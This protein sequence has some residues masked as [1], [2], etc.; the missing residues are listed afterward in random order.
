MLTILPTIIAILLIVVIGHVIKRLGLLAD[1]AW[2][3]ISRL[4]YWVLFPGL[5]FNLTSSAVV[6]TDFLGPFLLTISIAAALIVLFSSVGGRV[7]GQTGPAISSLIQGGLRHNG[8]LALSIL[9]G[10]GGLA[11]LQIGGIA[12]AFLVPISNIVAVIVLFMCRKDSAQANMGAAITREV[13]RNPLIGA[14]V[15]GGVVNWLNIPVPSFV[16]QSAGM[17]GAAALPLLLLCIGASLKFAAFQGHAK[18][19]FVAAISK[20]LIFPALMIGLGVLFGVG[21]TAL[22]V[23]AAVG[24]A[25]T[26]SS[27]FALAKEL[28]GDA[29]LMAEIISVQTLI[30]AV[31]MP[32]WLIT[33]QYLAS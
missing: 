23:L 10:A 1:S 20:I 11:A 17:L 18:P 30:A 15:L 25:P 5:L 4:C 2:D 16:T 12:V 19:L 6:S 9:Q 13:A 27:S 33:A 3:S 32:L 29:D 21:N 28:G 22:L 7:A 26:A 14:V 24:A 31:S 8:F